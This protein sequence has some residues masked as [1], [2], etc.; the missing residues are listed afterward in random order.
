M[1][2][3]FNLRV[4]NIK[5][6]TTNIEKLIV[7]FKSTAKEVSFECSHHKISLADL[8][9]KTILHVSIIDSWN[10]RGGVTYQATQ[11]G[12]RFRGIALALVCAI[13]NLLIKDF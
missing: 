10:K 12:I 13:L 7:P 2:Q 6:Q 4:P 1:T 5:I 9:V 11:R 3:L 8:K